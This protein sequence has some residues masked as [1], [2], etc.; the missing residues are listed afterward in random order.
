MARLLPIIAI[1]CAA[2]VLYQ[3]WV[4]EKDKKTNEEKL[5]WTFLALFFNIIT[6]VIYFFLEKGKNNNDPNSN[7]N[8]NIT[9]N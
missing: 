7:Q 2:W 6:A 3:V 9:W 4:V 1:C 8:D 5:L